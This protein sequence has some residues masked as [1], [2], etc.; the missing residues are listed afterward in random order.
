VT[1]VYHP[2]IVAGNVLYQDPASGTGT[3]A[4]TAVDLTVSKGTRPVPVPDLNGLS[5]DA[6]QAAITAAGMLL[7]VLD[8]ESS[9]TIPAGQVIRQNPAAGTLVAPGFSVNLA[10]SSGPPEGGCIGNGEKGLRL[11]ESIRAILR[12][13]RAPGVD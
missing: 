11:L 6:A 1:E 5:Y 10:V 2:T 12:G 3:V 13:P 9:D 4:G 8:E 7:G